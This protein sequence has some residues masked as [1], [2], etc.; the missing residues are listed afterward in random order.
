MLASGAKKTL[1]LLMLFVEIDS[2]FFFS[3]EKKE[4]KNPRRKKCFTQRQA[5]APSFF[6]HPRP[7]LTA[8]GFPSNFKFS[9]RRQTL[10][11][12]VKVGLNV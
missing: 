9:K 4:A 6:A 8:H 3:L 11:F 12:Q 5:P 10:S 7:L 2:L 1:V